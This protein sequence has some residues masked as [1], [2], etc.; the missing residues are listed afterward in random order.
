M[1][2]KKKEKGKEFDRGC[3]KSEGMHIRKALEMVS[4]SGMSEVRFTEPGNDG[5]RWVVDIL[6]TATRVV[7]FVDTDRINPE[8]ASLPPPPHLA[9]S[10]PGLPSGV[11]ENRTACRQVHSAVRSGPRHLFEVL[12][13]PI[14]RDGICE[15]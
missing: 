8:P 4:S 13:Q 15:V 7:R 1:L 10:Q 11:P 2:Y 14:R 12:S 9:S 5:L 3:G 6:I